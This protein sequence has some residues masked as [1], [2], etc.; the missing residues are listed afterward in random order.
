MAQKIFLVERPGKLC[1]SVVHTYT[2]VRYSLLHVRENLCA[3]Q[4]THTRDR[5]DAQRSTPDKSEF[6]E[7]SVTTESTE[8]QTRREPVYLRRLD[9]LSERTLWIGLV[10]L[11]PSRLV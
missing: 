11:A 7:E 9:L 3:P 2:S 6:K 1:L 8:H 5:T 4:S 10:S